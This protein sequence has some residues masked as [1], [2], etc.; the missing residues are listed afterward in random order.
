VEDD[1]L[2][3]AEDSLGDELWKST[4]EETEVVVSPINTDETEK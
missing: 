1:V 4:K 2:W 3:V